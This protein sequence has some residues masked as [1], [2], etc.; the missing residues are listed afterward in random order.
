[1][2][3][4]IK[5]VVRDLSISKSRSFIVLLAIILGAFGVSMMT[6]AYDILGK[7]LSDNFLKT[8]PA[9][10]TIVADSLPSE[11]L[12]KAKLLPN[13]ESVETRNKL[14]CRVEIGENEFVPIMLFI[15]EDFNNVQINTFR[16]LR[17]SIPVSS[18]EILMER[19]GNRLT[20]IAVDKIYNVTVPGYGKTDLKIS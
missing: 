10:F 8:N 2:K 16:L 12:Q 3:P 6:T 18:N 4:S 5:K 17:G 1:M 11:V 19:T 20:D 9:A 13:I 7:N 15:V 14:I